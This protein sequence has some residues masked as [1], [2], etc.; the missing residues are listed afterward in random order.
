M[1]KYLTALQKLSPTKVCRYLQNH[2]WKELCSLCGGQAIQYIA[3]DNLTVVLVPLDKSFSDYFKLLDKTISDVSQFYGLSDLTL[4]GELL[5]PSAD[6]LKWRIID[7]QTELGQ[8]P[9]VSMFSYM[10]DIRNS[11]AASMHDVL[12]PK[13]F[14]AKLLTKNINDKL[15]NCS[16]GQTEYGSYIVNVICPLGDYQYNIFDDSI[17]ELPLYRK[18]N[19]K[20]ME[21]LSVINRSVEDASNELDDAVGRGSVSVNFLDSISNIIS[22]NEQARFDVNVVRTK[23]VPFPE[24]AISNI[25]IGHVINTKITDVANRYRPVEPQNVRKTVF[26][27]IVNMSGDADPENREMFSITLLAISEDLENQHITVRLNYLEN[28]HLVS[29]AFE[30]GHVVRVSGIYSSAARKRNMDYASISIAT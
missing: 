16:F 29:D 7:E 24:D 1:I 2:G 4:L 25:M 27:K 15:A 18:V 20:M 5:N 28:Y 23:E 30:N 10:Q 6:I 19:L 17:E 26:G 21:S 13:V 9:F 12:N 8:I 11:M 14:H 22:V 3:N